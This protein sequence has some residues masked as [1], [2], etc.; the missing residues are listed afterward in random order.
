[1]R[2]HI[3]S[4]FFFFIFFIANAQ[5]SIDE[6][7]TDFYQIKTEKQLD[8]F[9]EKTKK[10]SNPKALAYLAS[11]LMWKAEYAFFPTKKLSFFKKGK[12]LLENLINQHPN[13][14][15]A[16]YIRALLKSQS[17][18]FLGYRNG[19]QVDLNYVKN[20]LANSNLPKQYKNKITSV[21]K[22][23]NLL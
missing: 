12:Q 8:L 18:K 11:S 23:Y 2:R 1:M 21:L 19:F 5:V 9:I 6:I 4:Y 14:I 15:E 22:E 20:N 10:C 3:T 16:R 7:R 17:P 13:M